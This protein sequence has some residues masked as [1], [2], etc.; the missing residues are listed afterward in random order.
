MNM[1]IEDNRGYNALF[2]II[3]TDLG[4]DIFGLEYGK[5]AMHAIV[6]R[7]MNDKYCEYTCVSRHL[8]D[9]H[10]SDLFIIC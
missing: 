4:S 3:Q 6:H 8:D 9:F 10:D 5:F 7:G 1:N 2:S